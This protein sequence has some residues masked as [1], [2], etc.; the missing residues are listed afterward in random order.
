MRQREQKGVW[1]ENKIAE[2]KDAVT[3][4]MSTSII[5]D[6]ERV[7]GHEMMTSDDITSDT[8]LSRDIKLS[9]PVSKVKVHSCGYPPKKTVSR[10]NH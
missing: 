10:N 8:E 2:L 1:R 6:T 7:P 9:A 3:E 5:V 4:S